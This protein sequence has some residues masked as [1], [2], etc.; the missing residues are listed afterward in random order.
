ME[1]HN[2]TRPVQQRGYDLYFFFSLDFCRRVRRAGSWQCKL[3]QT[4][5]YDTDD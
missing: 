5:L 1:E 2:F 3:R 4:L